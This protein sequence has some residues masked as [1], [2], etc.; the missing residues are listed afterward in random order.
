[1]VFLC[2]FFYNTEMIQQAVE[3]TGATNPLMFIILYV[4][5]N[6]IVEMI[7]ACIVGVAI[8]KVIKKV[9]VK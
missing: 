1:M 4:G 3:S 6:A 8:T 7:V 2:L 5:V 9:I